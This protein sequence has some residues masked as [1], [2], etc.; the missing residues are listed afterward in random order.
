MRFYTNTQNING[1]EVKGRPGFIITTEGTSPSGRIFEKYG[2]VPDED[3]TQSIT[4]VPTVQFNNLKI[5]ESAIV[6]ANAAIQPV[7][8]IEKIPEPN[9]FI[10]KAD[11]IPAFTKMA[12][13]HSEGN[14]RIRYQKGHHLH[15]SHRFGAFGEN[16]LCLHN[17][18][19]KFDDPK[20]QPVSYPAITYK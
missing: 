16:E 12:S 3:N 11:K 18:H 5:D 2:E 14:I 9:E 7:F 20:T 6:R 19:I 17:P 1:K 8:E 13:M 4:S 15:I 10:I